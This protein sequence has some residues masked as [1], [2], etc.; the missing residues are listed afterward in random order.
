MTAVTRWLEGLGLAKYADA[1]AAGEIDFN[2]L[3]DLT[4]EDLKELGLPI[5]PRRIVLK[6][7]VSLRNKTA[8]AGSA[9]A[10]M[11]VAVPHAPA[12]AAP[13][14]AAERR[15]LT[16]L[17]CDLVGSTTLATRLDPEDFRNVIQS[18][19][20]CCAEIVAGFDGS[21]AQYLG[22][23]VMVRFGY[24][25]AHEDDA[26]QAV[27]CGL[28]IIKA[29]STL[30]VP[31]AQP[32]QA[33]IGIATGVVVVGD[34]K[35]SEVGETPNLASRLQ[36]LAQPGGLVIADS[37]KKLIG[38]LFECRDIGTVT[39][40]GYSGPIQ[41][42]QVLAPS[43]VESRFEALRSHQLTPLIGR[44]EELELLLRRWGQAKQG[45]GRVVL[46]SGEPGIGKSRLAAAF[47]DRIAAEPCTRMQ[48]FFSPYHQTSALYAIIGQLAHAAGFERDDD[49]AARLDKLDALLAR[50]A[51]N[52]ED[53]ALIAGLMSLPAGDRYPALNLSPQQRKDKTLAALIRQLEA[54]AR[55]QPV[56]MV[57]EDAH[58]SDPSSRELL[59]LTIDRIQAL[60]VL[61]FATFRPE[62]QPAWTGQSHVTMLVLN[63]LNRRDGE[64]LVKQMVGNRAL[65]DDVVKDIVERTDGVPLFVE[66]LT[67]SVLETGRGA[68]DAS[69]TLVVTPSP[70]L[71]VPATLHAPFMARLDAL[72]PAKDIAQFG[73]AI[74][75][76]FSFDLL[77]A[78]AERSSE[79]LQMG[80]TSLVAAGL[81]F[82]RGTLPHATFLF[83]H[84]LIQDAAYGTLLREPRQRLHGRIA[85]ALRE[86]CPEMATDHPEVLAQHYAKA[87][88]QETAAVC[89]LTAGQRAASRS[90][91][92][93]AIAHFTGGLNT[94]AQLATTR[95]RQELELDIR[96]SWAGM[97][98]A[99]KGWMAPEVREQLAH[100]SE[101]GE[102]LGDQDRLI[103]V[104]YGR[105]AH[106]LSRAEHDSALL[107]ARELMNLADQH[108]STLSKSVAYLCMGMSAGLR[109]EFATSRE[110]VE[111]SLALDEPRQAQ[112]A[113]SFVGY[114]IAVMALNH[115]TRT[116]AVLGYINNSKRRASETKERARLFA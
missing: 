83:K 52:S 97:L 5:G 74:G 11:A 1:F 55:E 25:K 51:T 28:Q 111:R 104:M 49:A 92:E 101:L 32:L 9:S 107:A 103:K 38:S 66:E 96:L 79:E 67:K 6:A 23:G 78:V 46:L 82:Q 73:S 34:S 12:P 105:F 30:R 50:T 59:D 8:E 56:L 4:E 31:T 98:V 22:D 15:Q 94:I 62:F 57:F 41:A 7:I 69:T 21:V 44:D 33:R 14:A 16:V 93:E 99:P 20:A 48:Y 71:A 53:V 81:I 54:L 36:G 65:P 91:L 63:R 29:I 3:V 86:Q 108:G 58:W 109:G 10:P 116:L 115:L 84:A 85:E 95:K 26:A 75:R 47:T 77:S 37:T 112:A 61:L 87:G 17:F 70:A 42:W 24:P 72:G 90:A 39:V 2:E 110:Y 106:S 18:Y 40:K 68:E 45:E 64:A 100:A 76:E 19:H 35:N 80:L 113:I 43:A 89:W 114:D 88:L 13:V 102:H 27:R 60:P